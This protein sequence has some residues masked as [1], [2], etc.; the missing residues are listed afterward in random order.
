MSE[1]GMEWVLLGPLLA[2]LV[3]VFVVLVGGIAM[4][5]RL[6]QPSWA[7]YSQQYLWIFCEAAL[8]SRHMLRGIV[9][10]G[11]FGAVAATLA[12][13]AAWDHNPMG[14]IHG[15]QGV[16]WPYLLVLALSWMLV[17]GAP[18]ALLAALVSRA[19]ATRASRERYSSGT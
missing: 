19:V 5:A 6:T 15:P 3:I 8:R 17:V 9:I 18:S 2:L 7:L 13:I 12:C 1:A 11:S 14:E 4:S 10:G 16:D